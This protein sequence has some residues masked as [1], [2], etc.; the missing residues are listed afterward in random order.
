VS[1]NQQ[2]EP[3]VGPS[4]ASTSPS[5]RTSE[6]YQV[7]GEHGRGGLG[8]V[9][10][11]HDRDLGRD[12]AIKE[13][14]TRGRSG[15]ARFMRE[16]RI[17]ARLEHPGIVPVH[18]AG[19]W[20][21]G[22]PFYAMKLVA[23]RPLRELI[24]ER[25]TVE[26]RIN[27]LH[28]VIAVA[29]AIAYAHARNIIHRDLKPANVIVGDFGETI[30]IDW[31]LAKDLAELEEV[32]T[33]DG[34]FRSVE[35]RNLTTTGIA[36]GTPTY[37]APEQE[38]G[39]HV[40]QRADVFAIGAMLWEL[41]SLHKVPPTDIRH[42][43]QLLRRAGI[44][45]DLVAIV[46]KALAPER[47]RRYP[48][49]GALAADL[50]AFKS[51]ARIGARSYSLFDMLVHWTR[52]HRALALSVTAA[53]VLVAV[54]AMAYVRNIAIQRDRADTALE[55]VQA[56]QNDLVLEHAELLLHS[57]PT[58]AASALAGYRG[59]DVMRR[60]QLTAEAR[61]RGVAREIV[62][63]HNDTIFFLVGRPDGSF[64]SV[65][66]DHRI[67]RTL[68]GKTTTLATNV[69]YTVRYAYSRAHQLLA[70]ATSPNGV[71][72][73][74]LTSYQVTPLSTAPIVGLA[75]SPDGSRFAAL[76][77][78]GSL[79]VWQMSSARTEMYRG[80]FPAATAVIFAGTSRVALLEK[81]A[82]RI[83]DLDN[84]A[85]FAPDLPAFSVAATPEYLVAGLTDGNL[86]VVSSTLDHIAK[87]NVCKQRVEAVK[88]VP[89]RDL[90]AF[91]CLEGGAGLVR[92]SPQEGTLMVVDT[93]ET[94]PEIMD[95]VVDDLGP[96]MLAISGRIIYVH[97][98][99]TRITNRLEGQGARISAIGT[100]VSGLEHM[101]VGDVNGTVRIWD[102]PASE[103]Q[104]LAT[105]PGIP[106]GS[107]FSPN[108]D[109]LAIYGL[110]PTIRLIRIA[111]A[112]IIELRGHTG[113]VGGVHFSPD[114]H[115]LMSFSWDGTGR[116]WRTSDGVLLRT[117][118]NHHAIVEDG[119][120][121][122]D[123]KRAVSVGDDGHLYAWDPRTAEV[124]SLLSRNIPLIALEVLSASNEVVVQDVAGGLWVVTPRGATT[125]IRQPDGIEIT[126]M[127]ASKDGA[128]LGV[129]R[130][131]GVV[132]VYHTTDWGMTK[133]LTA[134]GSIARI[135]FDPKNR[136]VLV[137]SEDGTIHISPLDNR[138]VVGW[139]KLRVEAHDISYSPDGEIV[140][141][142]GL[143]GGS[144]FYSMQHSSWSY[145][146]D[147]EAEVWSGQCSPDG[148]YFVS[149]D[150]NGIVIGRH[151]PTM[152]E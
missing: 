100:P 125:L 67:Q 9:S 131:D 78:N 129:G 95:V 110:D 51:G 133:I 151:F 124:K 33:C 107:R 105:I 36:L 145:T 42:R 134:E 142:S 77:K 53:F 88:I 29:D 32:T 27:L 82:L 144:W 132:E 106:L 140:S 21:D 61:G 136:D 90:I 23:G 45:A 123:G 93:F 25:T 65:G 83:I 70:Y 24:A 14:L 11:A 68:T 127:R 20:P 101:L 8:V 40:D 94:T 72:L 48:D 18:E 43:H 152:V 98:I 50:K 2:D 54:G 150:R 63:P 149:A 30:V 86:A 22:T 80:I 1:T 120:F 35:D 49:A 102:L 37:M 75:F 89:H 96:N 104:L 56:A 87:S 79:V 147:H 66:E 108:G 115:F 92:Y 84:S 85:E 114:G 60:A 71:A 141:I 121:I 52:R 112:S 118:D 15:E 122:D 44:D 4:D 31:G 10:R 97:N 6:R 5:D 46:D 148:S 76:E 7:I 113:Y 12:V 119:D 3:T 34:P 19:R 74:D 138:R 137:Y 103:A 47:A 16:A 143:D 13:L 81:A 64:I 62:R 41:C 28:H 139:K 128:L 57:D 73:M 126:N 26:Q 109:Y 58:A 55:R 39:E 111:D 69:S 116:T 117:F 38:R 130:E 99:E 17:T 135:E 146:H 59:N 91:G